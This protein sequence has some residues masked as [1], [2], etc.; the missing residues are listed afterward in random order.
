MSGFPNPA[1]PGR[2]L[3]ALKPN[4]AEGLFFAPNRA[5]LCPQRSVQCLGVSLPV[6]A[7]AGIVCASGI[8]TRRGQKKPQVM[9]GQTGWRRRASWERASNPPA[10]PQDAGRRPAPGCGER[11]PPQPATGEPAAPWQA[12]RMGP[13]TLLDRALLTHRTCRLC[14]SAW[15]WRFRLR[16]RAGS[17]AAAESAR[18]WRR[19]GP[20]RS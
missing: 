15:R 18:H 11:R 12:W 10:C 5:L 19:A 7:S 2:V 13:A 20:H 1:P 9:G 6:A 8:A 3:N 4:L 17:I 14:R 16:V